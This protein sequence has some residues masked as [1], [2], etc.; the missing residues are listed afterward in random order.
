M[1]MPRVSV[2]LPVY[3]GAS[4]LGAAVDSILAQTFGDFEL[5]VLDDGSSDDPEAVVAARRDPRLRFHRHANRGLAATLNVGLEL[6]RAPL[7]ARQDHDDL[8][9]PTRLA[10]QVERFDRDGDL[11]LLGTHADIHDENGPTGRSHRPP[12]A[13]GAIRMEMNFSCPFV[14][15][16]VMMRRDVVRDV[17]GYATEHERQP[18]DFDLWSRL[19]GRGRMANL[20]EALM[21]YLE[22]RGSIMRTTSFEDRLRR[23]LAENLARASGLPVD[24]PDLAAI[25]ALARKEAP[26]RGS[27]WSIRRSCAILRAVA[28]RIDAEEGGDDARRRAAFWISRIRRRAIRHRLLALVGR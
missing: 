12:T 16:S 19:D 6:A 23:R 17:G 25:H 3:D 9:R 24:D 11:I 13:G 21:I 28:E 15:P 5:I 8:S 1:N 14:H 20:D 22:R 26:E 27:G 18:E 10:R 2:L 4:L 7:V